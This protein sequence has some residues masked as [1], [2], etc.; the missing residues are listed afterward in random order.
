MGSISSRHRRLAAALSLAFLATPLPAYAADWTGFYF[1]GYSGLAGRSAGQLDTSSISFVGTA[2]QVLDTSAVSFSGNPTSV[3]TVGAPISNSELDLLNAALGARAKP[4][5]ALIYYAD[6]FAAPLPYQP[7]LT[8]GAIAG[9]RVDANWRVEGE[10][11]HTSFRSESFDANGGNGHLVSG[12][13][14]DGT[15]WT[16]KGGRLYSDSDSGPNPRQMQ[17]DTDFLFANVWYDFP[18]FKSFIPYVGGGLGAARITSTIVGDASFQQTTVSP[19]AQVGVGIRYDIASMASVDIGYRLK[20]VSSDVGKTGDTTSST[21][22]SGGIK[23]QSLQ[24][25]LLFHFD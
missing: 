8:F 18:A 25:G 19:A 1:G 15:T 6:H 2:L 3:T 14:N 5:K 22:Q 13:S 11:S 23:A 16:W 17:S 21:T 4:V 10:L 24:A 9:Y 20:L 12:Q 7:A